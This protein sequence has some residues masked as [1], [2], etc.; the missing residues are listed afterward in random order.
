[1]LML[2]QKLIL[3]GETDFDGYLVLDAVS[4]DTTS[5]LLHLE[6][7]YMAKRLLRTFYGPSYS[8]I[9]SGP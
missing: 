3:K 1:M 4:H 6:P 8:I 2:H 5:L 9:E 7:L